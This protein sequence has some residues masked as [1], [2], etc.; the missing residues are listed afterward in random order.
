[1]R[2]VLALAIIILLISGVVIG[3]AANQQPAINLKQTAAVADGV[4]LASLQAEPEGAAADP[5]AQD[6]PDGDEPDGGAS[7]A[8]QTADALMAGVQALLAEVEAAQAGELPAALPP[9]QDPYP[10]EPEEP[11]TD[12]ELSPAGQLAAELV[13]GA[14]SLLERLTGATAGEDG[15][16][17]AQPAPEAE[18]ESLLDQVQSLLAQ[19]TGAEEAAEETAVQEWMPSQP[20]CNADPA[21]GVN[22][23]NC[24][25]SGIEL[26]G[27]NLQGANLMG[28]N[29]SGAALSNTDLSG[30][31]LGGANFSEAEL[32]SVM[33]LHS[34][35]VDADFSSALLIFVDMSYANL[36]GADFTDSIILVVVARH[37]KFIEADFSRAYI[38][39]ADL[40]L[41]KFPEALF[42]DANILFDYFRESDMSD[43][44]FTGVTGAGI[45]FT[46]AKIPGMDLS[47]SDLLLVWFKGTTGEPTSS[48]DLEAEQIICTDGS[49]VARPLTTDAASLCDW[50]ATPALLQT[51]V[52]STPDCSAAAAPGVNWSGCDKSGLSFVGVD[53][54]DANLAGTD[55]S[56]SS[57]YLSRAS[58]I[59]ANL[60]DAT[61]VISN[62]RDADLSGATLNRAILQISNLVF[63]NLSGANIADASYNF[64]TMWGSDLSKAGLEGTSFTYSDLSF[65]NLNEAGAAGVALV[66]DFMRGA[67]LANADFSGGSMN[68]VDLSTA[69]IEE[70]D[71][72]AE[73]LFGNIWLK[74]ANG[75]PT[76]SQD[77]TLQGTLIC[78]AGD[79]VLGPLTT[80]AAS[81][82]QWKECWSGILDGDFEARSNAWYLPATEYTAEFTTDQANSP[83]WSVRTGIIDPQD[84]TFSFSSVR[85]TVTIPDLLPVHADG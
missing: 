46:E 70:L 15:S 58:M 38:I 51:A 27:A 79:A 8:R 31:H 62:L 35:L 52:A 34:N 66:F 22:W 67:N 71:L 43:A 53:L 26:D 14:R 19:I 45:E 85:Q 25:K 32:S 18:G 29:F 60:D 49:Y 57:F 73:T 20:D 1:M 72:S 84:N 33:L 7:E 17:G 50:S 59:G 82:C 28:T 6:P 42:N 5:V 76:S 48:V 74:G 12:E 63:A 41:S 2:I 80:D 21:P 37:S 4:Q 55:F 11:V 77:L 47:G 40:S 36:S 56:N 64:V 9:I 68:L 61:I 81:L 3:V 44:D 54:Q 23:S 69:Q 16:D 39:Y 13:A 10:V 65:A 78:P 83:D 75:V 24:D 30:A